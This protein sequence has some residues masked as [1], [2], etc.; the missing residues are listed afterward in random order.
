MLEIFQVTNQV[1]RPLN[2]GKVSEGRKKILEKLRTLNA[3]KKQDKWKKEGDPLKGRD[4]REYLEKMIKK[5][6]LEQKKSGY[7]I[8]QINEIIGAP[9]SMTEYALKELAELGSITI[10][11]NLFGTTKKR[12]VFDPEVIKK[13]KDP[14]VARRTAIA[15]VY[16]R[17]AEIAE[18]KKVNRI[19]RSKNTK[20]VL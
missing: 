13:N 5:I 17:R 20:I 7:S 6:V 15:E 2:T 12:Y 3:K 10:M 14:E 18:E 16:N 4:N 1:T 9:E 8:K 11:D 19:S